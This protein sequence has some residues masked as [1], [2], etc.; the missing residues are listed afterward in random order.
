MY[1]AFYNSEALPSPPPDLSNRT[2]RNI[3]VLKSS[4]QLSGSTRQ[5]VEIS[6]GMLFSVDYISHGNVNTIGDFLKQACSSLAV[7][8]DRM[9]DEIGRAHV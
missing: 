2:P 5:R 4:D 8:N 1:I 7:A 9:Y 3:L 6:S